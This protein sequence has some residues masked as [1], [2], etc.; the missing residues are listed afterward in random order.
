ML[1]TMTQSL[2]FAMRVKDKHSLYFY[3]NI[4]GGICER[5]KIS[6]ESTV[7]DI[8]QHCDIL[9]IVGPLYCKLKEG[10]APTKDDA[11]FLQ[12]TAYMSVADALIQVLRNT[13]TQVSS[14]E[15]NFDELNSY[16]DMHD[17]ILKV[18][19]NFGIKSEAL[20]KSDVEE[21]KTTFLAHQRFLSELLL[22]QPLKNNSNR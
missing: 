12:I 15:V 13:K 17:I 9:C 8:S 2:C 6:A 3:W 4:F 22:I 20:L 14:D 10:G 11:N 7:G 18:A 5:I 21:K 19:N 16:L 1:T